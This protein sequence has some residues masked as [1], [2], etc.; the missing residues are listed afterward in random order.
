MIPTDRGPD[1]APAGAAGAA[2]AAGAAGRPTSRMSSARRRSGF[3]IAV[4]GL[5]A[6]TVVLSLLGGELAL[7][8][9]L[10][11]YLLADVVVA[12][13]GGLGPGLVAAAG[14]VFAANWFFTPPFHTLAVANRDS[15]VELVV[16]A[17]VALIVSLTVEVAARDRARAGRL[18]TEAAL[19]S[20]LTEQPAAQ[21]DLPQILE[22]VRL[23]F[24]MASAALVRTAGPRG[25]GTT[26]ASVGHDEGL[27]TSIRVPAGP[28]LELVAHG[29]RL[30]AEDRR[31]LER[32]A[33]AAARAWENQTVAARATELAATDRV[34][35][36]L[37]AAV[38]HDL[39]TP[40]AGIKAAVSSL[41]QDDVS[42]SETE[43]DELLATIEDSADRL[44]ELIAN[45]LDMSR[46]QAG[47]VTARPVPIGVDEVVSRALLDTPSHQ[48]VMDI[49]E[50][51]PLV[52]A[53]PGLLE[54]VVANLVDN[55]RRHSPPERPVTVTA[56]ASQHHVMVSVVDHGPG[57]PERQWDAMFEP[58][59][60]LDDRASGPGTGL[61][62]AIVKGFC[63]AMGV[64]VEPSRTPG[65]GL[66]MTLSVG[67]ERPAP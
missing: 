55:A 25:G 4:L 18:R 6:L 17:V 12:A 33:A 11:L 1:G 40:L 47:G 66:T 26:I 48:V 21:V 5:V 51:L 10:L 39:R 53:D 62:L 19:L 31:T 63:D 34:R 65:G 43:H 13:V 16:F 49:P 46:L 36:A 37:L 52:S 22:K 7:G 56:R 28:E 30:F 29:P 15:I 60:R 20:R 57:V 58:F 8:S 24:G 23:T 61:G 32:L 42:W 67:T 9:V 64:A 59:R 14:S 41:R 3:A 38:G 35:S 44:T 27:P 50:D 45:L 2:D 54:R